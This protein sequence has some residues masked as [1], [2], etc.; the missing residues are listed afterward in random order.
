MNRNI[1]CALLFALIA[2]PA[3]AGFGTIRETDKEIVVEYSG[4]DSEKLAG[5]LAREEA[6]K[7]EQQQEKIAA[8][9]L[10]QEDFMNKLRAERYAEDH[11]DGD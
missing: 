4:D 10:A 11:K 6:Q 7:Q 1:Y 8:N 5:R 3:H 9:R 2:C